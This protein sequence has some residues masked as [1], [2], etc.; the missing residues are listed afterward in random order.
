MEI[1]VVIDH[2][3]LGSRGH[4]EDQRYSSINGHHGSV[5]KGQ[6]MA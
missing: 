3:Y 5:E 6:R 1:E 4:Y 2:D